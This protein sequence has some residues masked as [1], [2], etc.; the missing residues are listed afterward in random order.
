M[1]PKQTDNI[2]SS[3]DAYTMIY[4]DR[5]ISQEM[6]QGKDKQYIIDLLLQWYDD[7][8]EIHHITDK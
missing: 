5:V 7:Y 1:K 2:L 6:K 3:K 8:K 4:L